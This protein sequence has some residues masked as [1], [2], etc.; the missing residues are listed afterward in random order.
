[1]RLF[2]YKDAFSLESQ[3]YYFVHS[4]ILENQNIKL[5]DLGVFLKRIF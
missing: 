5:E 2:S 1:M 3:K 4:G